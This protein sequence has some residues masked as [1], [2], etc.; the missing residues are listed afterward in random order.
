MLLCKT[1]LCFATYNIS[2]IFFSPP[3]PHWK[4]SGYF[5]GKDMQLNLAY[6][7][8]LPHHAIE[9]VRIHWLF[10]SVTVSRQVIISFIL[11][12]G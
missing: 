10:D 3:D 12:T 1:S 7:G 5:L 11:E 2:L 6:I 8:S 9:Q 4:D